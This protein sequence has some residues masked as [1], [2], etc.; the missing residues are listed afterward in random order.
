[1]RGGWTGSEQWDET[2]SPMRMEPQAVC[3]GVELTEWA[4][5]MKLQL[6]SL[7]SLSRFHLISLTDPSKKENENE[8]NERLKEKANTYSE[9]RAHKQHR[10][11][12]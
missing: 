5:E 11:K 3:V 12:M 9:I 10:Q 1:M 6:L 8:K 2:P 7:L 4:A